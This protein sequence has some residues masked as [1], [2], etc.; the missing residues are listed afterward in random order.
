M[1]RFLT[2]SLGQKRANPQPVSMPFLSCLVLE[3]L[4]ENERHQVIHTHKFLT[5]HPIIYRNLVW[6]CHHLEVPSY[7]P[8]FIVTSQHSNSRDQLLLTSLPQASE[9]EF[10]QLL[11]RGTCVSICGHGATVHKEKQQVAD[12]Y[13]CSA[14]SS[15]ASRPTISTAPISLLLHETKRHPDVKRQRID[16]PSL[17]HHQEPIDESQQ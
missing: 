11:S 16:S 15:T 5:Q 10:V 13:C 17:P 7:L 6:Y 2:D 8:G 4:L 12:L 9:Q 14:A 1:W 3:S